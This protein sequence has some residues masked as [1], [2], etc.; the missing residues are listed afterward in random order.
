M[1]DA[2]LDRFVA[3]YQRLTEWIAQDLPGRGDIAIQLNADRQPV[4]TRGF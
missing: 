1:D 4:A 2:A 3:H